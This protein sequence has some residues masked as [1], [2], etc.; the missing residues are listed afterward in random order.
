M[1]RMLGA[2][3]LEWQ[4][5]GKDPGYLL[6]EAR[7]DQFSLWV[8]D[9]N[10]ALTDDEKAF[11]DASLGARIVRQDAES[12]RRALEERLKLR[13]RRFLQALVGVFAIA[14][15]VAVVLSIFAFNAQQTA[16]SEAENRATQQAIAEA[17]AQARATAQADAEAERVIAEN[18]A[19]A[20]AI[21]QAI[22][23]GQT[24]IAFARELAAAA[25]NNLALN[26]EVSLLLALESVFITQDVDGTVVNEA[27]SALHQ[28]VQASH[29]QLILP[30]NV[31]EGVPAFNSDG[32]RIASIANGEILISDS[33][34]GE[35][36]LTIP[37]GE[38]S[39]NMTAVAFSPDGTQVAAVLTD[40]YPGRLKVWELETGEELFTFDDISSEDFP[41]LAY[42]P[43]GNHI[44]AIN[45]DQDPIIVEVP[46]GKR[47]SLWTDEWAKSVAFSP[48]GAKLATA[49]GSGLVAIWDVKTRTIQ[50]NLWG[51]SYGTSAT[52][53]QFSQDGN[54]LVTTGF[55]RRVIVWNLETGGQEQELTLYGMTGGQNLQNAA[56]SPDGKRL[57]TFDADAQIQVWDLEREIELYRFTCI[58]APFGMHF[59]H[60]FSRVVS[61]GTTGIPTVCRVGP[62]V[63]AFA[64]A[65]HKP[66][67][68]V[69]D[70]DF[71]ASGK[72]L[73]TATWNAV[74]IWDLPSS[75]PFGSVLEQPTRVLDAMHA[76]VISRDGRRVAA[77]DPSFYGVIWDAET[78]QKLRELLSAEVFWSFEFS[79]DGT[80]LLT[81]TESGRVIVFD[82]D[83]RKTYLDIQ[84]HDD[85]ASTA[86]F[87]PD[88]KRIL[89]LRWD[90][91]PVKV[92]D[93]ESGELLQTFPVEKRKNDAVF[94][95]D[96]KRIAVGT[97]EGNLMI[98]EVETGELLSDHP[99][100]SSSIFRL[101]YSV[102]GE[103]IFTGSFD[104]KASVWDASTGEKLYTM[105]DFTGGIWYLEVS[106][107]GKYLATANQDGLTQFFLLDLDELIDLAQTRIT[108]DLTQAECKQYLHLDECP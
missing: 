25:K 81:S 83:S 2:A 3:S 9:S 103:R 31:F 53:V 94:S 29:V 65:G 76:A 13:S 12:A 77:N 105:A 27:E 106:P 74:N 36:Q 96:G 15:V 104:G 33:I 62:N 66:G 34:S 89:S 92:W 23:E 41:S 101:A 60:D 1:Q 24:R 78:G 10:V 37:I 18:E 54:R 88:G 44:A 93:A 21:Q 42:S 30:G 86:R 71:D 46:S 14:A 40:Q 99:G 47:I 102:D 19:E 8:E 85:I 107:D 82:P 69:W 26:P 52:G 48:D 16:Q 45:V 87:S 32:T 95:P 50:F 80:R 5:S 57:A 70:V 91:E 72:R 68:E 20:R 97:W 51:H 56:L 28:A 58:S 100:E 84:A 64:L 98:W 55:D 35:T 6:R 49:Y 22:A 11:L 43:D 90:A 61:I 108:R 67:Y 39:G 59:N 75:I 4:E 17:Q 79:P 73:V 7:L 63:E 38:Y